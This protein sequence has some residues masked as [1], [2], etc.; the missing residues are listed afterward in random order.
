MAP[1]YEED[2]PYATGYDALRPQTESRSHSPNSP[3]SVIWKQTG[4]NWKVPPRDQ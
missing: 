4:R 1:P 3:G 2:M